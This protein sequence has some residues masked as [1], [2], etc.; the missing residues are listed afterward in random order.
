[1]RT[2]YIARYKNYKGLRYV[3]RCGNHTWL[4]TDKQKYI[5]INESKQI[6]KIIAK[7]I[8]Q[9]SLDEKETRRKKILWYLREYRYKHYHDLTK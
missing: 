2:A 7:M 6:K 4:R 9:I 8:K 3:C 5:E 1:M